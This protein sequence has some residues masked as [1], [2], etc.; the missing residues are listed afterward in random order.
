MSL[1]TNIPYIQKH[2]DSTKE[3][4][5][6]TISFC[7]HL[8][9]TSLIMGQRLSEYTGHGPSAELDI[10]LTNISLDYIGQARNFYQY[11]ASL[12]STPETE[13]TL[14]YLRDAHQYKNLLLCELPNGNWGKTVLK[15]C[16][17]SHY[18]CALYGHL[19]K[20]DDQQLAAIAEK[21]LKEVLYHRE[22][23]SGWVIRLGDGTTGS[24]AIMREALL[25]LWPY[26][27]ELF[28]P[29]HYEK[30][31]VEAK[32]MQSQWLPAVSDTLRKATLA[33]PDIPE[34]ML[35]GGKQGRHTEH[36]GY[37]LAEMQFLQRAYPGLEW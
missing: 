37:I 7:L 15:V 33:V 14:A 13:D 4:T 24:A 27:N 6:D 25:D 34:K 28:A 8:A 23:A 30:P 10:A 36:L 35:T 18:L 11:A 21:S 16:F 1:F 5:V 9:D 2:Q 29:A 20:A 32:S 12:S 31:F 22:W 26:T 3:S 19:N 17:L